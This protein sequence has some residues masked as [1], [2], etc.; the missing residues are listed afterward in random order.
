[1]S[2]R[3]K[4]LLI[5]LLA[6]ANISQAAFMG[7]TTPADYTGDSIIGPPLKSVEQA[8]TPPKAEH[9]SQTVPPLKKLRL[10]YQHKYK[11]F[12]GEQPPN[13][14]LDPEEVVEAAIPDTGEATSDESNINPAPEKKAKKKWFKRKKKNKNTESV[15]NAEKNVSDIKRSA[16]EQPVEQKKLS[17]QKDNKEVTDRVI[18]NCQ[19]MDY[20]NDKAVITAHGNV[21]ITLV[22]E[23][24]TLYADEVVFDKVANTITAKDKVLIKK[25]NLEVT[26]DYIF[27]D[28]NEENAL[29]SRPVSTLSALEIN[30]EEA[31]L[32]ENVV[33]QTNGSI[34]FKKSAPF[35]FRSGKRGPRLEQML[36]RKEDTLSDDLQEGRY[37]IKVT[38]MVINSEKEHDTFL[39][40]KATIYKD[41][42][43]LIT[44]PRTKFYTNKNHDYAEGDFIEIGS[45]RDAGIFLGPGVVFK[46]PKGAALKAVPFVS[47]KDEIGFGGMLR[48]NSG[49]N[50]TYLLYGSQRDKFIGRGIQDLDDNLKIE[51]ATND[52]MNEWFLG[53]AR[54]EY[55]IS[56]VYDKSYFNPSFLGGERNMIFRHR[57]SGGWYKD[58]GEDRYYR[59]LK[60]AGRETTRFKYMAE[61]DQT[62]WDRK[63]ADDLTWL[64]LNLVGQLSAALY[65]TGDT[66]TVARIG[67]RIHTQYKRWMQDIGYFQSAFQDDSPMPVYDAYR[68]GASNAYIRET[69]K[70]NK[71][72]AVSWFGSVTLSDDTYTNKM[73]QECAFYVSLGPDDLR[74]NIGYDFVRENVYFMVDVALDPKGTE[75]KYDKLEIK[76]PDNLGKKKEDNTPRPEPVY[77]RPKKTPVLRNAIVEPV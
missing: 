32:Q 17:V 36:T 38:K 73:F 37:K 44:L 18:M 66:Q 42:K 52:Y 46:L 1:M 31:N 71:M 56:L 62:I 72:L 77:G 11:K 76:N 48:F 15:D 25:K 12:F 28:L 63:N 33:T 45:K 54:P 29:I 14:F 55:G 23:G 7:L 30:A 6:G 41:G 51:Y 65:G 16:S 70:L 13:Q 5:A 69:L 21:A 22:D 43:K 24:A 20:D 57:V 59:Q 35:F 10:K 49:T 40:Q 19:T 74:L 47:Y 3:Y 4:I 8:Y 61:I 58:I 34:L 50:E 68:Y 60:G 67:P 53:R 39:V 75:V 64:Q 9:D 26:G 27:I 2:T